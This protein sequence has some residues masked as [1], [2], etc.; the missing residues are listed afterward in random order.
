M[1]LSHC[2]SQKTNQQCLESYLSALTTS[3][4]D[5]AQDKQT[6]GD[7]HADSPSQHRPTRP[8]VGTDSPRDLNARIKILELYTL[9]VLPRNEEWDYA[10]EFIGIS[11]ILD[12]ENRDAFFHT[13]QSLQDEVTESARREADMRRQQ[14]EQLE[15][16]KQEALSQNPAKEVALARSAAQTGQ[17]DYGVGSHTTSGASPASKKASLS[18]AAARAPSSNST[19][20]SSRPVT[21]S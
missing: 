4:L 1:L 10:R 21:T 14:D 3:N 12:D 16:E 9:H 11:Q 8:N 18:S 5:A 7:Q 19:S 13:L 15:R 20:A 17:T 2:Q 6:N